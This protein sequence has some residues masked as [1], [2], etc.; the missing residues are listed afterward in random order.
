MDKR[1][2]FFGVSAVV[3]LFTWSFQI[4]AIVFCVCVLFDI[5]N[6]L[7]KV[8]KIREAEE[9]KQRDIDLNVDELRWQQEE[10]DRNMWKGVE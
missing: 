10:A 1:D 9:V 5:W 4:G 2:Y 3:A 6:E 8:R 7:D